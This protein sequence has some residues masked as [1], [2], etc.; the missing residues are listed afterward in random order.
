MTKPFIVD[1]HAHLG[2]PGLFFVPGADP[3]Y[4]LTLMDRLSIRCS[5]LAGDHVA[6]YEGG[7][8]S[9]SKLREIYE[10]SEGRLPYLGVFDP[11]TAD[12]CLDALKQGADWP[13]FS[14]LK[15]HPSAHGYAADDPI[16][17]AV[18]R[19]AADRDL[20]IM[21]HSWSVSSYNPVQRYSTPELFEDYARKFPQVK[22][23]LGHA[24]GRGSGRIETV[25][26]ANEYANVYLDFAGDI[27]CYHLIESLVE[28]VPAEK[29]LFGSDFPWFDPRTHISQ[30]LLSDIDDQTK[31][32]ILSDNARAVYKIKELP[33]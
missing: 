5:I 27:N 6:I 32:M 26:M 15:I 16:Y 4:L 31:Q 14:G 25:R 13:G 30:V 23:V 24:G 29:I 12:A 33:C 8:A 11:R 22:L 1:A 9:L 7:Q 2:S 19:L 10:Q 3:D 17:E 20:P 28:S 21:T 18:W